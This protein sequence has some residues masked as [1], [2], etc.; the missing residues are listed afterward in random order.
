MFQLNWQLA[1]VLRLLFVEFAQEHKGLAAGTSPRD[2]AIVF[3]PI[4][5]RQVLSDRRPLWGIS[6]CPPSILPKHGGERQP[7]S[8]PP[9]LDESRITA[10][11][12]QQGLGFIPVCIQTL[13]WGIP[14]G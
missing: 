1:R 7:S 13:C 14:A 8:G 5:F 10:G 12:S 2:N 6:A 3:T 9:E 4:V 11:G